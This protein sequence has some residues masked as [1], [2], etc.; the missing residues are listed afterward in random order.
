M[1]VDVADL[2]KDIRER[3]MALSADLSAPHYASKA[4]LLAI[5][6][7]PLACAPTLAAPP[8]DPARARP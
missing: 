3:V 4:K 6:S 1:A 7:V 2:R 8:F 5:R